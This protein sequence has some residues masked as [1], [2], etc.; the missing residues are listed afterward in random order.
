MSGERKTF[1]RQKDVMELKSSVKIG[2]A[3]RAGGITVKMARHYE[4]IGLLPP[5]ER[6]KGGSRLFTRAD[7]HTLRFVGRGRSLGFSLGA[8][9][10]LLSLWQDAH[11]SNAETLQL[12]EKHMTD[13]LHKQSD[14]ATMV[15]T[16]QELIDACAGDGRPECPILDDLA[17]P[18]PIGRAPRG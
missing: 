12:A 6:D 11:R 13:L 15:G 10:K 5:A 8:I 17:E 3:A 4:A 2:A 7:I 14:L 18:H 16:L 1:A 9:R